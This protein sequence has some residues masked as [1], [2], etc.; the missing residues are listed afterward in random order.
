MCYHFGFDTKKIT[1]INYYKK[2]IAYEQDM[3]KKYYYDERFFCDIQE[4]IN[5]IKN[6]N[7][8]IFGGDFNAGYST[9]KRI[10]EIGF[11]EKTKNIGSTMVKYAYCN[12]HIF[13]N[14]NFSRYVNDKNV[15]KI[16]LNVSP[17]E[18]YKLY[19][20]HYGIR[21]TIEI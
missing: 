15:K 1:M 18:F 2:G 5:R 3:N 14:N 7:M 20:D 10:E 9:L 19:S 12:D 21:C 17:E 4:I 6:K 13:V 8:I 11:L 16:D